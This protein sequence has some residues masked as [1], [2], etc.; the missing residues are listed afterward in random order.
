[1]N[2]QV[3]LLVGVVAAAQG[4]DS[5]DWTSGSSPALD[6]SAKVNLPSWTRQSRTVS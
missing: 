6:G 4:P 1:M 2:V 3:K 5:P